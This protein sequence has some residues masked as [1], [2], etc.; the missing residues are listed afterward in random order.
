MQIDI[1]GTQWMPFNPSCF[2]MSWMV[3]IGFFGCLISPNIENFYIPSIAGL[4]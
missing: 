2:R 1:D 4:A 3:L